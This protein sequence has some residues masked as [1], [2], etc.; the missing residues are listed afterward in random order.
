MTQTVLINGQAQSEISVLDRGLLY[1]DGL[2]ET[3]RV[4]RGKVCLWSQHMQRL[5]YGC[6]RLGLPQPDVGG[7]AAEVES[8][9]K[10][11]DQAVIK[12][13]LTRGEGQRGFA[14]PK[15][16]HV[17]RIVLLQPFPDDYKDRAKRGIKTILCRTRLAKQPVL[18]GLKHLNCLQQVMARNEWDDPEIMEGFMLDESDNVI[19]GCMSNVFV[20]D[21]G[22]LFTPDLASCGVAGVVRECI[23]SLAQDLGLELDI[24]K[25]SKQQFL[26]AD[27]IFIS[28]S[29]IGV[30][31]VNQ[32]EQRILPVGS[33]TQRIMEHL[34]Y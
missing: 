32:L 34:V 25:I 15:P 33:I 24:K 10:D 31:P 18:A 1:G 11:Q 14:S 21:K 19:E 28:N 17:T 13:L 5:T 8:L 6:T 29:L 3:I 4:A 23:L 7:L 2:F 30:W 16:V 12:I 27:E 22:K 20:V 9:I 26:Q